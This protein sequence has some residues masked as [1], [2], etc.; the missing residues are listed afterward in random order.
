MLLKSARD[1]HWTASINHNGISHNDYCVPGELMYV[2]YKIGNLFSL[3]FIK[4]SL[5]HIV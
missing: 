4:S 3:P 1:D 2:D 5:P